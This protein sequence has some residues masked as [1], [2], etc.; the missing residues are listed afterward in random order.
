MDQDQGQVSE[1]VPRKTTGSK[2][3]VKLTR[4][5]NTA[6]IYQGYVFYINEPRHEISNKIWYV[7]PAKPQISL[8]IHTV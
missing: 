2:S 3:A 6:L 4:D 1:K 5:P 7:R 8:R